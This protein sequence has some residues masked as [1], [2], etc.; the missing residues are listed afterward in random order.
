MSAEAVAAPAAS[1]ALTTA[2]SSHIVA[3]ARQWELAQKSKKRQRIIGGK[4]QVY[5]ARPT[6]DLASTLAAAR[7]T[8]RKE[9][10]AADAELIA[11]ARPGQ[12]IPDHGVFICRWT[13]TFENENKDDPKPPLSETFNVFAAPQD[14]LDK[15][16]N[17]TFTFVEAAKAVA[18]LNGW[19]SYNGED[20]FTQRELFEV[21]KNHTYNGGWF[22]PPLELLVGKDMENNDVQ[23]DNIF[24]HKDDGD[25]KGTFNKQVDTASHRPGSY[26]SCTPTGENDANRKGASF[27]D[28]VAAWFFR[29][30]VTLSC[31]PI[32]LERVM[33]PPASL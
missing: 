19:H 13:V 15:D 17:D 25:L 28:G 7:I 9:R 24:A 29:N 32:R 14:V 6:P 16:G 12:F 18:A 26:W 30:A 1:E 5:D 3:V 21:L 23:A 10:L 11:N 31:R 20:I 33:S 4:T 22:I 27:A 8:E 2:D